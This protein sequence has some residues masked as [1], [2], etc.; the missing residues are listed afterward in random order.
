[1]VEAE[2]N[3]VVFDLGSGVCKGGW[4]G[5]EEP[6]TGLIP[7]LTG[8]SLHSSNLGDVYSH[9][10]VYFGDEAYSKGDVLKM[11]Y[12]ILRGKVQNWDHFDK[13][14]NHMIYNEVRFSPDSSYA[15]FCEPQLAITKDRH[16]IAELMLEGQ[17][18]L[19]ISF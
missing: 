5:E 19:G 1:M 14:L 17:G 11:H 9:K 7:S 8:T 6:R 3:T 2:Y 18:S 4:A 13:L 12:P 10:D 15:C 16:K